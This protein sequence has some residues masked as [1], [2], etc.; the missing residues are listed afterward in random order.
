MSGVTHGRDSPTAAKMELS[1]SSAADVELTASAGGLNSRSAALADD[2]SRCAALGVPI[3]P[4]LL[5]WARG[6]FQWLR[7]YCARQ[8]SVSISSRFAT[9]TKPRV[10]ATP[11]LPYSEN[12]TTRNSIYSV[13]EQ[14]CVR[15]AL[16]AGSPCGSRL[17][18]VA[19]RAGA[20]LGLGTVAA[21]RASSFEVHTLPRERS[22]LSVDTRPRL[23]RI[24]LCLGT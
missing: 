2:N 17:N 14:A 1:A 11:N 22:K 20:V 12:A 15:Q 3:T 6:G 24:F 10:R 16:W 8:I 9:L 4:D 13:L 23:G 21:L 18:G 19:A 5:R 7:I